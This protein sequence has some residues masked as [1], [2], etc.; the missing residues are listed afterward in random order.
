[1]NNPTTPSWN[2]LGQS[3]DLIKKHSEAVIFLIIVPGLLAALGSIL[4]VNLVD[5][6]GNMH[7]G[8]R[9]SI[10]L[11]LSAIG[12]LWS[13]VNI[14]PVVYFQLQAVSGQEPAR[15]RTYYKASLRFNVRLLCAYLL[16]AILVI[17]GLVLLIIPGAIALRRYLLAP[18][19]LVDKNLSIGGALKQS[20]D[21]SKRYKGAIW[22]I[23]GIQLALLIVSGML[24]IIPV[25][26][27]L[28]QQL[29]I[30]ITTFMLALRYHEI[31]RVPLAS[32]KTKRV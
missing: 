31:T 7:L 3:V 10:G 21:D 20:G 25:V 23:L 4:T 9:E 30:Y 29:A 27:V 19:Y 13:I 18:Y 8:N 2:L 28:A 5:A 12:F 16:M 1:M 15:L 17:V 6:S 14:G 32:K 24:D 11:G 22:G 26:G